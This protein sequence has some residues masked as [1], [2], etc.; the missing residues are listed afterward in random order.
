MFETLEPSERPVKY[1]WMLLMFYG[2]Y[3]LVGLVSGSLSVMRRGLSHPAY[4]ALSFALF[5]L[6]L[7]WLV[8]TLRSGASLS[9]RKAGVRNIIL[10]M[11]FL[12]LN[13]L[14]MLSR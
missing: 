12:A 2:T 11:V 8:S 6:S 14:T 1:R 5:F 4:L 3:C 7:M 9:N 13:S 10:L